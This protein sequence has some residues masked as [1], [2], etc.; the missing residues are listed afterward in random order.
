MKKIYNLFTALALVCAGA[1]SL[2]A[3]CISTTQFPASSTIAVNGTPGTSVTV[4]TCNY[5]GEYSVDN[6]TATGVYTI[7]SSIATDY[8]TVTDNANNVVAGAFGLTVLSVN[9]PSVGIYR[10]HVAASAPPTCGAQSSCRT[11]IIGR[12]PVPC[13][14]V[15]SA[16]ALVNS[17]TVCPGAAITLSTNATFTGSGVTFQWQSS[18]AGVGGPYSS[19]A[20]GTN[21]VFATTAATTTTWYQLIATCATGPVSSTSTPVQVNNGIITPTAIANPTNL[22]S[23]NSVNLSLST[24]YSGVTYNWQ[25]ATSGTGP[26][27][28]IAPNATVTPYT[29]IATSTTFYR[30]VIACSSAPTVSA[31]T[32][33]LQVNSASST[34]TTVPYFEGFEGVTA[35]NWPNC[36][37]IR[38]GDWATATT[39]LSN[40]R[41]PKTGVGYAYTAWST[42]AGGDMLYTM[43]IQLNAG[44]TYSADVS[45]KNDGA[46][47][48][49]QFSML[50]ATAQNTGA[51]TSTI[52][53]LT[54]T[55]GITNMTYAPLSNTFVVPSTGVY[56]VAFRVIGNSTPWYFNI[57]DFSITAP[58]S[59]NAATVAVT[60]GSSPICDGSSVNLTASGAN[61]YSWSSGQTTASV[62]VS[63]SLTTTY[64][65]TGTNVAACTNTA[66]VT[67][68]VNPTPTLAIT[69]PTAICA[70]QTASL[71]VSGAT[72]YNWSTG[73]T[74]AV[75]P[76]SPAVTSVYTATGTTAGCSGT[77]VVTLT[78]NANP[79]VTIASP[80]AICAGQSATLTASGASSYNW[81]NATTVAATVVS[82]SVTTVYTAT[83]TTNGCVGTASVSLSINANPTVAIAGPSAICAGQTASLAASG[84]STYVW[85]NGSTT[86]ANAV[87]PT[88]TTVYTA[89]GTAANGCTGTSSVN[90]AV[91]ALPVVSL[92]AATTGTVCINTPTISLTGSPA[93]GTY[94][95]ANVSGNVFTPGA[96]PGTFTTSYAFT[97]SVTTCSNTANAVIVVSGCVGL[98]EITTSNSFVTY[99]NPTSAAFTLAFNNGLD[100]QVTVIDVTGKVVYTAST[101]APTLEIDL[102]GL[103]NG[104]YSVKVVSNQNVEVIKVVKQ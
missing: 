12:P 16:T 77:A 20:S 80:T 9:I 99:P 8:L 60:G 53:S 22:C 51:I 39:T 67:V 33:T 47:G 30:A 103:A 90:L 55:T 3:Q 36:S 73:A 27:T 56:Y 28:L 75:V 85:S 101:N 37:W 11:I 68:T 23:S 84:A 86:A 98:N 50:L 96:T 41:G 14:G 71:T 76:V 25:S 79:T 44:I 61:N 93:G 52:A 89:T 10:V 35:P 88:V 83:G 91:N 18:T 38:T 87:S 69:G 17:S 6:F 70:G 19:I 104:I 57:D 2:K 34:P 48:W 40:N 63:P 1:T 102:A 62:S 46:T 31:T 26:F 43:P 81:S 72:S 59:L 65:V 95:G 24:A 45:H 7:S 32:Q 13:T 66:A 74:T 58:C 64:I 4:T 94:S 5:G 78:V 49:S 82:P 92:S 29:A 21:P 42:I 15:P 54:S 97:N 100:K